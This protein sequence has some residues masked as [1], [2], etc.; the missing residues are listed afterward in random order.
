MYRSPAK[1]MSRPFIE[2]LVVEVNSSS[3]LYA[4]LLANKPSCW[5]SVQ[6]NRFLVVMD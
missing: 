5:E 4:I 6:L 2:P 1:R 3:Y